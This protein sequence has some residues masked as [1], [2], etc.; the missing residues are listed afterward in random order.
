MTLLRVQNLMSNELSK[1]TFLS[2]PP[3]PPFEFLIND[4]SDSVFIGMTKIFD[5][6][7]T[8]TYTTVTNPHIAVVGITGAG[9]SFFVKDC[10]CIHQIASSTFFC[11]ILSLTVS[12]G[13]I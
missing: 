10:L 12:T 1:R 8:W 7:F 9:K 11:I 5:I 3:E 2:R 6:P 4:P 13:I